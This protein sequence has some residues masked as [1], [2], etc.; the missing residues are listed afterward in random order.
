[1]FIITSVIISIINYDYYLLLLLL[2]L[3]LSFQS[4]SF[5]FRRL[6]KTLSADFMNL[7]QTS[8]MY[9]YIYTYVFISLSL[10]IYIYVYIYIYTYIHIHIHTHT[11]YYYYYYYYYYILLFGRTAARS[12]RRALRSGETAIIFIRN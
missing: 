12:P 2:L 7:D 10:Y 11:Y 4:C 3:L 8:N 6:L 1:M 5:D 9:I